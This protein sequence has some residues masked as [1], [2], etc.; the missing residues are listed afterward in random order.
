MNEKQHERIYR[1]LFSSVY[2]LYLQKVQKKN[3]SQEELNA[4]IYW[5]TGFNGE[6]LQQLIE[7]KIDFKTFFEHA[8]KLNPNRNKIT[9]TICGYR[10]E[11]I[12]DPI[13]Q[14]VRYLD[15]LVD[16]L[17]KGKTLEK[18]FRN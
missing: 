8:P 16:E 14:N 10:V 15:K 7:S 1:M 12:Q 3:R 5:L 18:I 9:G 13:V 17:A 2:P 11:E 4:L 6:R